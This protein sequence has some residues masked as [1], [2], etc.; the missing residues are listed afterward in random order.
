M[1]E[2]KGK[3]DPDNVSVTLG[4]EG[5]PPD[6]LVGKQ[7]PCSVERRAKSLQRLYRPATVATP[8]MIS[9][10]A[11]VLRFRMITSGPMVPRR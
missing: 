5:S 3:S 10:I 2:L 1:G 8:R 11:P 7:F 6:P 4:G 9:T